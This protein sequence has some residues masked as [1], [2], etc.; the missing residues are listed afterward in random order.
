MLKSIDLFAGCGGLTEGFES[1]GKFKTVAAVEW[2]KKPAD[3]LRQRID[4]RTSCSSRVIRYD[5]QR[6]EKLLNGST[7]DD[8]PHHPGLLNLINNQ[9]IDVII[10]G[11]PCQAYSI[12]GRVRCDQAMTNDYRNYLF[13][14]YL[15]VVKAV[16]PK[17]CVFENVRGMLSA[18]PGGI[19]II[20]RVKKA[21]HSVGY[22]VI[23]DIHT[24]ALFDTSEFGVPQK[25][26]RVIIFAVSKNHFDNAEQLLDD[27]YSAM[28][29]SKSDTITTVRDAF[30]GLPKFIPNKNGNK[31]SHISIKNTKALQG[32]TPRYHN[33]R[34]ISIFKLLAKDIES[35]QN[36]YVSSDSLKALYTLKTG[37]SSAVHKYHVLRADRPSNTI[38]AHLYKDGLR[39]IHPDPQQA[40]SI[41]VR[42]AARLQSFPDDFEFLGS[43]GDQYKMIGNAVPPNFAAVI[44][45]NISKLL[46]KD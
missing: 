15:K 25:R 43:M 7:D 6:T 46:T 18:K 22:S 5:I 28:Q 3:T 31:P 4:G 42:E 23:T 33:A 20:E 30:A 44:A 21:F 10:G 24:R 2:E 17:F 11:P 40:R 13:E 45:N 12:A 38:P 26:E 34:D 27:F 37:K 19:P 9:S 36:K 1:T 14:S 16:Q 8:Y 29:D 41:T 39:H 32:H 35:G